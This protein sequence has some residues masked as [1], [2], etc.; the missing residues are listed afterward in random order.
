LKHPERRARIALYGGGGSPFNHAAVFARAGHDVEFVFPEDVR[1]GALKGFDAFVMPGGGYRAMMGQIDPLGAEG[2][3]ALREYVEGGGMYI[4]CCA[5]SYDAAT[6]APSFHAICPAQSEMCLLPAT[7]WN[8]GGEEWGLRSPGIGVLRAQTVAREHPV[9]AGMPETF[10]IAHYNGPLFEG[11]EP[12]ARVAGRTER[13]TAWEEALGE[14][15][16]RA[17]IDD[18]AEAGVANIVAGACGA[19]RVVL[20]GSHPEFGFALSMDDEQP[21]GRMLVNAIEWQVAES[22]APELPAVELVTDAEPRAE[23]TDP[24]RVAELAAR[25]AER[26]AQL[27]ARGTDARWLQ[28]QFAMSFFGAGP[29]EIWTASL[30][31]IDRFAAEAARRA[32]GTD[33]RVLGFRPPAEWDLDGGYHGVVALLEQ[34]LELLD[35]ALDTWDEFDPGEPTQTPYEHMTTSPYHLVAGSYLAAVGRVGAAALLCST[36][37]RLAAA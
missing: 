17:L 16:E 23:D 2:A 35:Q 15:P 19:G 14:R 22:G 32:P 5:G 3:R 30:D 27:R 28:P 7:V 25:L 12:L 33:P 20:F 34:S 18:A 37:G 13:F 26:T 21:P 36:S 24:A 1:N 11:A 31:A 10:E 4:G 29:V 6:V 8:E 9:M